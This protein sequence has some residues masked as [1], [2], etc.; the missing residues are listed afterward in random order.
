MSDERQTLIEQL[1]HIAARVR[2]LD[3][4]AGRQLQENKDRVKHREIL[5]EKTEI[6]ASL[7]ELT[8]TGAKALPEEQQA[9]FEQ[10]ISELAED[11]MQAMALG[12][13]FYMSVLLLSEDAPPE[14]PNELE[15]LISWLQS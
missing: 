5:L 9:D 11:A 1:Q 14:G 15:K 3:L 12:S 13:V 2:A 7:S 4:E 6:L 8:R 10:S